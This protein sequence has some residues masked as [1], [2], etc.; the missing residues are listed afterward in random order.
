MTFFMLLARLVR[1]QVCNN[2]L[3]IKILVCSWRLVCVGLCK[4]L[5]KQFEV[6]SYKFNYSFYMTF[7]LK[8]LSRMANP[9]NFFFLFFSPLS[10][11]RR[12]L[13]FQKKVFG[14]HLFAKNWALRSWAL[15]WW[16]KAVWRHRKHALKYSNCYKLVWTPEAISILTV[17]ST[18]ANYN[19]YY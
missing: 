9:L 4:Q 6:E 11:M 13:A 19:Q 17:V 2:N 8:L 18:G 12:V 7:W 3:I 10:I 1:S 15:P 5:A 16:L 14:K